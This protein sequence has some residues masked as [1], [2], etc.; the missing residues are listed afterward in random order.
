M[1]EDKVIVIT[2][3]IMDSIRAAEAETAIQKCKKPTKW[4]KLKLK[5]EE[6]N[7]ASNN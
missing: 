6:G 1:L 5:L 7:R 2:W 3:D 4:I